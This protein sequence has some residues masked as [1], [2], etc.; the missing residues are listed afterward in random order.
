MGDERTA[1]VGIRAEEWAVLKAVKPKVTPEEWQVLQDLMFADVV[2]GRGFYALPDRMKDC[3]RIRFT[4]RGWARQVA[5]ESYR[6][7]E[8]LW[9]QE[10]RERKATNA[11]SGQVKDGE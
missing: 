1:Y 5:E 4:W 3:S 9:T 2:W 8:E 6:E 10:Q 11:Q 7:P